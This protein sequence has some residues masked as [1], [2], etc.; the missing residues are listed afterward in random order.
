M[1]GVNTFRDRNI[2]RRFLRCPAPSKTTIRQGVRGGHHGCATAPPEK[3]ALANPVRPADLSCQ[4]RPLLLLLLLP[5][6]AIQARADLIVERKITVGSEVRHMTLKFKGDRARIE[7]P[8]SNSRKVVLLIDLAK[9]EI[10][11]LLP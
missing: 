6:C 4:M 9:D 10:Y 5:F 11:N 1:S 2:A 3:P 8:Q 7:L